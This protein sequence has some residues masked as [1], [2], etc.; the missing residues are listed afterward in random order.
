MTKVLAVE[1]LQWSIGLKIAVTVENRDEF[2]KLS[3]L[4]PVFSDC[5]KESISELAD[6]FW[7]IS[8]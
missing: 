5:S 4:A 3:Q 1:L 2:N 7:D 6:Y 8:N